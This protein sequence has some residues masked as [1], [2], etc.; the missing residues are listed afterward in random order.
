ML[1]VISHL[2]LYYVCV[3]VFLLYQ[4][5]SLSVESKTSTLAISSPCQKSPW[6]L[7]PYYWA[8]NFPNL[9]LF[10]SQR[11]NVDIFSL[12]YV[13]ALDTWY[14]SFMKPDASSIFFW[15]FVMCNSIRILYLTKLFYFL[16]P[17]KIL[18]HNL[19][20]SSIKFY[21]M[22]MALIWHF[23]VYNVLEN[24]L[25]LQPSSF[26]FPLPWHFLFKD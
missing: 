1:P 25:G 26:L 7:F 4:A 2:S 15:M 10:A 24:V 17:L 11:L 9:L 13:L 20:Y 18:F 16:Q 6:I 19:I 3:L 21:F 5:V 22:G 23:F 8:A 14:F 12:P